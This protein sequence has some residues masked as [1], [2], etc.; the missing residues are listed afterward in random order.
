[1]T[2]LFLY[3]VMILFGFVLIVGIPFNIIKSKGTNKKIVIIGDIVLFVFGVAVLIISLLYRSTISK[4]TGDSKLVQYSFLGSMTYTGAENGYYTLN[5]SALMGGWQIAVPMDDIELT[6]SVKEGTR[7]I[8]AYKDINKDS[9]RWFGDEKEKIGS[10]EYIV[11]DNVT[12]IFRD[13]S[14]EVTNALLID[15]IILFLF[16]FSEFMIVLEQRK[17]AKDV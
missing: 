4:N 14:S 16:N 12:G 3:A 10:N 5:I 9:S 17:K 11:A 2:E 6:A 8:V 13:Y 1:M 15:I 7:V